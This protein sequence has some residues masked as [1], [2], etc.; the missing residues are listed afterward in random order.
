MS[1][2]SNDKQVPTNKLHWPVYSLV[3]LLGL[4]VVL[5]Q[6]GWLEVFQNLPSFLDQRA[7][8]PGLVFLIPLAILA[9]YV[10][11]CEIYQSGSGK[12]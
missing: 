11:W 3:F 2:Q 6:Q 1:N 9:G 7:L 10:I 8:L 4:G 12:D 5:H